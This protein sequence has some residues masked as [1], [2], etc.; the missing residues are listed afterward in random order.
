MRRWPLLNEYT[1]FV[2]KRT[3]EITAEAAAEAA[4]A[5]LL[6]IA[7]SRYPLL[8][9]YRRCTWIAIGISRGL[10]RAVDLADAVASGDLTETIA[11][12][13]NDEVG[14]LRHGAERHG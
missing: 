3:Q 1:T 10:G 13:S 2:T 6:L 5:K 11:V 9:A 12:T 8:I 7:S 14:D 4:F